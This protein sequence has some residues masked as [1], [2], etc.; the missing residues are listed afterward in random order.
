MRTNHHQMAKAEI[1]QSSGRP[2]T[3]I[4]Q[5][6]SADK[7]QKTEPSGTVE[8]SDENPG[9]ACR[10]LG[11]GTHINP[12]P[13]PTPVALLIRS[14]TFR[15]PGTPV[16]PNWAKARLSPDMTGN[17]GTLL[18]HT[19]PQTGAEEAVGDRGPCLA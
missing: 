16:P 9:A 18:H 1:K 4:L 19:D 14:Q 13:T 15:T 12:P 11:D 3:R 17:P 8:T 7:R 5:M 6:H 10:L 2:E